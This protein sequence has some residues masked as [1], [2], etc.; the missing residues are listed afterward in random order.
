M[1]SVQA[2]IL[3]RMTE[4]SSSKVWTASSFIDIGTRGAIDVA[5]HRLALENK[6]RRIDRG[7][8]DVPR[9]STL[10]K[11]ATPPDHMEVVAAVA[12]RDG[13]RMLVDGITAANAV[14][15]T[16]AVPAGVTVWTDAR[17]QPIEL[18][19]LTI[20]FKQVAP[21][22]LVWAG[23]PAANIV[24]ALVWLRD[25]MESDH[26]RIAARLQSI[27][28]DPEKGDAIREDLADGLRIL[29][30]WMVP[31]IKEQLAIGLDDAP[32]GPGP[33]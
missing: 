27:L 17:I 24:Q 33:R 2:Q 32:S 4:Q 29:P 31:F 14:G 1:S 30:S 22:R 21:S 5:L 7:L 8:Y 13:A 10:T 15:M 12:E 9:I 18:G 20:V 16:N 19:G 26:G 3:R 6:V 25:V 23:R 11:R 28:S